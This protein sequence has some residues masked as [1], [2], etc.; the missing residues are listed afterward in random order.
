MD[1]SNIEGR[2][3]F[4][5]HVFDILFSEALQCAGIEVVRGLTGNRTKRKQS[6]KKK[7][8]VKPSN[9][10]VSLTCGGESREPGE[11]AHS[12]ARF[13]SL[14][15]S[16][17]WPANTFLSPGTRGPDCSAENGAARNAWHRSPAATTESPDRN[18]PARSC[19]RQCRC[20]DC[21]NPGRS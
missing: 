1:V 15:G 18:C 8:E 17:A 2:A 5:D 4:D 16:S 13:Q 14:P 20:K 21:Q 6:A 9:H 11:R 3:N 19:R 12:A 10:L 7:G